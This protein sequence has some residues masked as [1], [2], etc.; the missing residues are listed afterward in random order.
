MIRWL[1]QWPVQQV[2][3]LIPRHYPKPTESKY[4]QLGIWNQYFYRLLWWSVRFRNFFTS[5]FSTSI[6]LKYSYCIFFQ[7][8]FV[9]SDLCP[10]P[11]LP[12]V[13][14]CI[15][16]LVGKLLF[17][18]QPRYLK[19]LVKYFVTDTLLGFIWDIHSH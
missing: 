16:R 15:L 5:T 9:S 17:N 1:L 10:S 2:K 11:P 8:L 18:C 14:W 12:I 6:P 13:T 19:N 7:L 3:I 4:L